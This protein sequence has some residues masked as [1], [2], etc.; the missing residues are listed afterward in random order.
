M[1]TYRGSQAKKQLADALKCNEKSY[2]F[3]FLRSMAAMI[4][5]FFMSLEIVRVFVR[6]I[7]AIGLFT[8]SHALS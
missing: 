2:G 4:N 6:M 7:I 1:V 5:E 3:S 8:N